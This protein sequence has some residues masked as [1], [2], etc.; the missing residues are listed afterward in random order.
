MIMIMIL[1]IIIVFITGFHRM[2]NYMYINMDPLQRTYSER[3]DRNLGIWHIKSWVTILNIQ[4]VPLMLHFPSNAQWCFMTFFPCIC[5]FHTLHHFL[6]V[7]CDTI[8]F[9]LWDCFTAS[10]PVITFWTAIQCNFLISFWIFQT[11]SH[12]IYNLLCPPLQWRHMGDMPFH[13]IGHSMV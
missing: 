2:Y 11:G 8:T 4:K 3:V 12:N 9:N 5:T 10:E 6:L 7:P 1:M 13:F